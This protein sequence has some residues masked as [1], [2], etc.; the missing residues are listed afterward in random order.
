MKYPNIDFLHQSS[1]NITTEYYNCLPL[2]NGLKVRE[3][4]M[5]DF[6]TSERDQYIC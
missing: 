1:Q 6:E 4:A 5:M 2:Q 3:K